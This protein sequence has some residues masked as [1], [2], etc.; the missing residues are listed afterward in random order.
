M[1][2]NTGEYFF[3][4]MVLIDRGNREFE[5]IDGQQRITSISILFSAIKCFI[6]QL[7]DNQ[8]L[9]NIINGDEK[10]KFNKS[11]EGAIGILDNVLFNTVEY[12][13]E[14]ERKLKIEKFNGFNFDDVLKDTINC[15]A[16]NSI[17]FNNATEEQKIISH[18]YFDNRDYFIAKLKDHFLINN[19]FSNEQRIY[20]SQFVDFLKNRISVVRIKTPKFDIAYQIFEILNNRGL[21]LSNKDLLRNFIIREFDD[22]KKNQRK[23]SQIHTV[24][25]W[26]ELDHGYYLDNDFISRWVESRRAS[27][28]KYSAF[29]DL[30]DYYRENYQDS[31]DQY[32]IEQ[33]YGDLK[34]DLII[35][36]T[37]VRTEF[38]DQ[39][40]NN[41]I[42]FLLNA[43]N[44]R[45][46]VNL[47]MSLFRF[48]EKSKIT[49]DEIITFITIFEKYLIYILLNPSS[50][51]SNSPIY[52]SIRY[53]NDKNFPQATQVFT[54]Q[55]SEEVELT[56]LIRGEIKDNSIAKLL[57][58]KYVW[59]IDA[60]N[61]QDVVDQILDYNRSTLEHI[62]PQKP[63]IGTNWKT[64]FSDQF[65]QK[66]TYRLGNMTLLTKSMNSKI[67]NFDFSK[68]RKEYDKTKL[69]ITRE[70]AGLPSIDES[71]ILNRHNKITKT[72]IDDLRID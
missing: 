18:R 17:N 53:L 44:E 33:L 59:S 25:F 43:G 29:N 2:K 13:F 34:S 22:L 16:I 35:Y 64:D 42:A 57:I 56:E 51:F 15:F 71:V 3:G 52:E 41:K 55:K 12:G 61:P 8:D 21:P 14:L 37:I 32:A 4:S 24:E 19:Q 7:I 27:Q 60:Q 45:Y 68:K 46:T 50:K 6:K 36:S 69:F 54:L 10:I 62:I 67:R 47:L 9:L 49:N 40:L 20:L 28:Q 23:Y 26:N 31:I 48:K 70:I 58:S 66:Y 5:V 1:N 72:I 63:E 30:R 65:V 11:L 38:D 39:K